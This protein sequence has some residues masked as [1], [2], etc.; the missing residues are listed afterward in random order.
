VTGAAAGG[1]TNTTNNVTSTNGGTGNTASAQLAVVAPPSI[2]K[3]FNPASIARN[4][5]TQLGF[6][7]TNSAANTV[8]LMNVGFTDTLPGGLTVAGSTSS[9][10]GGTLTTTAPTGISL[11]GAAIAVNSQCQFSVTVTGATAGGYMNTTGNVTSANGGTG[12]NASAQLIVL[13]PPS[14]TKSFGAASVTQYSDI[15]LTFTIT[16]PNATGNLTGIA[17]TD[18]LPSGLIVS[19]PNALTGSCGGGAIAAVSRLGSISLSGATLAS[20]A[21]C[22]FSVNVE[23]FLPGLQTN[24]VTVTSA[25]G[26]TGN[27]STAG[28]TVVAQTPPPGNLSCP[29]ISSG[30][31]GVAFNGPAIGVTGGAPPFTFSVIGTLLAGLTLN[32]STGAITGTATTPGAFSIQATDSGGVLATGTCPFTF[33]ITDLSKASFLVRYAANLNIGESYLS[34]AN[35]GAN[36][37]PL[38]GPGFGTPSGNICVNM[39][40]FDASEELIACCSCLVTP[41]QPVNLGVRRDLTAKTLTGAVPASV[42]IKLLSTLAGG[43]GTGTSCSNSAA[44]VTTAT[45]AGGLAAWGTTLH[46]NPAGGYDS[47]ETPYSVS[48][49]SQGELS[50]IGNRCANILGNGSGF[51]VCNSCRPGVPLN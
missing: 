9:V 4:A 25:N 31:V 3:A 50:S 48:T 51:G 30:E 42:T 44:I 15:S 27:T 11:S 14:I 28:I 32:T 1:Y 5:T 29:A 37:D 10:C 24:F 36:G 34:I 20:G 41:N 47:T 6:T 26:G 19:S 33:G 18:S 38:S 46:A 45:L 12:N 35:T 49:L 2:T 7:I 21:A 39:Y 43:D 17:F 13:A 40:T 16:N 8:S 22:S 23:G